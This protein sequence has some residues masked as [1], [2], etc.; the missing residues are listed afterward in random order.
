MIRSQNAK[1]KMRERERENEH[2]EHMA[3]WY[4]L[5]N[6]VIMGAMASQITSLTIFLF[7]RFFSRRSKENIKA[8]L[9]GT[10]EFHA[11]MASNAGNVS[12]WWRHH[13]QWMNHSRLVLLSYHTC[14]ILQC[15]ICAVLMGKCY[16]LHFTDFVSCRCLELDQPRCLLV[17][18]STPIS[19]SHRDITNAIVA[20]SWCHAQSTMTF[21][22]LEIQIANGNQCIDRTC[23]VQ[24]F[25]PPPPP[26]Q[27]SSLQRGMRDTC[28]HTYIHICI[29][30]YIHICCC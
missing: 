14:W 5:Y 26:P 2:N 19:V 13:G 22:G 24:A 29:H 3:L 10:G 18:K 11:Q 20:A 8:P 9:P 27:I 6:D 7:N 28:M 17:A 16:N 1:C 15:P 23:A 21:H 4:L 25:T 12:I 30:T